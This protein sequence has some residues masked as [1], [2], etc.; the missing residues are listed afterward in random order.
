ML[1]KLVFG[2][3]LVLALVLSAAAGA[4]EV[5]GKSLAANADNVCSAANVEFVQ[6]VVPKGL[7]GTSKLTPKL[8]KRAASYV[9]AQLVIEKEKTHRW[10]ALGTPKEPAIRTAWARW[11]VLYRTVSSPAVA[12]GIAAAKR[13]DVKAF[14][15]AYG[16]VEAHSAEAEKLGKTIG[17]KVCEWDD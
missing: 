1:R 15:A 16:K 11:L 6:L 7:T 17:F 2:S 14:M 12:E 8:L 5:P 10:S 9:A 13:G 4:A 3:A